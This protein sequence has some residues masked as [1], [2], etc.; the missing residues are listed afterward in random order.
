M[1]AYA[2]FDDYQKDH[3]PPSFVRF[4]DLWKHGPDLASWHPCD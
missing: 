3:T 2:R 1:K 4:G